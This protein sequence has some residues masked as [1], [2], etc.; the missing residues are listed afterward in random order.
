MQVRYFWENT[1][2]KVQVIM[3]P[4]QIIH[5]LQM[6]LQEAYSGVSTESFIKKITFQEIKRRR[7]KKPWTCN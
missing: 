7:H 2:V 4:E 3:H 6:V 1:V 5:F